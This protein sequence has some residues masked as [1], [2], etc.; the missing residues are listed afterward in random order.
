VHNPVIRAARDLKRFLP[1]VR[2]LKPEQRRLSLRL[3]LAQVGRRCAVNRFIEST[4]DADLNRVETISTAG[5]MHILIWLLALPAAALML[6][7]PFCRAARAGDATLNIRTPQPDD[8]AIDL[9]HYLR[10][11]NLESVPERT[12]GPRS[13]A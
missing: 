12:A 6:A 7:L 9:Q 4:L 8:T 13:K 1:S 3:W 11:V 5:H 10:Y 2:V